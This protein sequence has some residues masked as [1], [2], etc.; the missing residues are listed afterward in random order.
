MSSSWFLLYHGIATQREDTRRPPVRDDCRL[1]LTVDTFRQQL[2]AVAQE[3]P[4]C[5][6]DAALSPNC[7]GL[8]DRVV[9]TFDDGYLNNYT[10]AFP[11][12]VEAGVTACFYVISGRIDHSAG[13]MTS[14]QLREM[15]AG[16]MTIG[17]HTVTHAYLSERPMKEVRRELEDSK[18]MLEDMIGRP[19]IHFALPGGHFSPPVLELARQ[20]GYRSVAT[21]KVGVF[22]QRDDP[23][24]IPHIAHRVI[25]LTR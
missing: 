20:C 9:I 4:I 5:S 8:G 21:C 6:I 3:M 15:A 10:E 19:V 11:A 12:L 25:P 17:S 14:T 7:S 24:R 1:T 16:G 13:Y 18:K 22:N 23:Y 2:A